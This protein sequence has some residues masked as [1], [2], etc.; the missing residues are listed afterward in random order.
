[1]NVTKR[2]KKTLKDLRKEKKLTLEAVA[3]ELGCTK[4]AYWYY[5]KGLRKTPLEIAVKLAKLF[6][7]TTEDIFFYSQ[8]NRNVNSK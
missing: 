6:C 2:Q 4:Q 5:E 8:G 3:D 1:M 7:V